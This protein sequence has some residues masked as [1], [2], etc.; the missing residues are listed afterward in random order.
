MTA[1]KAGRYRAHGKFLPCT[2]QLRQLH[3][4]GPSQRPDP[5]ELKMES[6]LHKDRPGEIS[7]PF[8]SILL[9]IEPQCEEAEL[10]RRKNTSER[11]GF[12][13]LA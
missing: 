4:P 1:R 12:S 3:I 10:G 13:G 2:E 7:I 11:E 9:P 6:V 5:R 8:H